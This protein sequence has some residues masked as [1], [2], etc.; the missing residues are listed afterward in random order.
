MSVRKTL[1]LLPRPLRQPPKVRKLR[2]R[3]G[4]HRGSRSSLT[5]NPLAPTGGAGPFGPQRTCTGLQAR[6]HGRGCVLSGRGPPAAGP[7]PWSTGSLGKGHGVRGA[8]PSPMQSPP[9]TIPAPCPGHPTFVFRVAHQ[10]VLQQERRLDLELLHLLLHGPHQH[11]EAV[12]AEE[13]QQPSL[14]LPDQAWGG[15]K[16]GP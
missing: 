16:A 14:L 10:Q 6:A 11:R 7:C 4:Q 2:L 9:G 3:E 12:Q 8:V 5:L 15:G 13:L 1:P